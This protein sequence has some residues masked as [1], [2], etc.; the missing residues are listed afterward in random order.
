VA[1]S[2]HIIRTILEDIENLAREIYKKKGYKTFLSDIITDKKLLDNTN[3]PG[4]IATE[5]MTNL[6]VS[7]RDT[8]FIRSKYPDISL[9]IMHRDVFEYSAGDIMLQAKY[10]GNLKD[11]NIIEKLKKHI[12]RGIKN[13]D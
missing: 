2:S 9:A 6:M 1:K 13:C 7:H 11:S 12:E 10:F 5:N 8:T 4:W 3:V